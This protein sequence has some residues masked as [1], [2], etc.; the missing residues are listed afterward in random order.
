MANNIPISIYA[1]RQSPRLTYVAN[2]LSEAWQAKVQV[3]TDLAEA[4]TAMLCYGITKPGTISV[5]DSGLLWETGIRQVQPETGSWQEL[6]TL[7]PGDSDIP[8]D[9]FSAIFYLLSRY[10]EYR[11]FSPDAH[12]RYPATES[13]LFRAGILRKPI[14]DLWLEKLR[15][16]LKLPPTDYQQQLTYDIDR[17][18]YI[19]HWPASRQWS[20]CLKALLKGKYSE[21]KNIRA[22]AGGKAR[23]PLDAFD[24]LEELHQQL[25]QEP[26]FFILA[27]QQGSGFDVNLPPENPA[28]QQLIQRL[29]RT[30]RLGVHPSYYSMEQPQLI[31]EEKNILE[32]TSGKS[33]FYSRQHF[34]RLRLPQTYSKLMAAGITD[35]FSMGYGSH[36]GF[37]AGTGRPFFWYDLREEQ[38]KKLRVHPFAFMDTTAHFYEKLEASVAFSVLKE[39]EQD[40]KN[41]GSKLITVFHNYSLGSDAAWKGWRQE[42][43]RWTMQSQRGK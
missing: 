33:I 9:L 36:L 16:L 25:A 19:K 37:R 24:F 27:A 3:V 14:L 29:S 4:G 23:D 42:Y 11:S 1:S 31:A 40:L 17:A 10:E 26:I 6:T 43:A 8:F 12:G 5:P 32:K 22:I 13:I 20:R 21:V 15:H 28:M 35:D 18:F 38:Q 34:M 39:M 30:G 2:W 41:C 7:F